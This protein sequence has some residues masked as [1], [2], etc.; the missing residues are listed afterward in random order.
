MKATISP[1]GTAAVR[2]DA[3]TKRFR[4]SSGTY[5]AREDITFNARLGAFV[6]LIGPSRCG[7]STIPNMVAGP[8]K[9][10]I[11]LIF[12]VVL[13][14]SFAL[15]ACSRS[16][17]TGSAGAVV[18]IAIGGRGALDFLP[19]YL[20]SALG[21][22]R[23]EG[24]IVEIQDFPGTSKA[25]QALLGGSA[26]VVAG[27]YE[28]VIHMAGRGQPV[29]AIAVLERWMPFLIVV[30][31]SQR[32]TLRSISDLKGK[33]IGVASQGST[34]HQFLNYIVSR[35]GIPPSEVTA[36]AVGV[37]VSLAAAV[38]QSSVDAAVTGPYGYSLVGAHGTTIL[39]DCRTAEGAKQILGTD[40]LPNAALI[41]KT[42]WTAANKDTAQRLGRALR[43]VLGWMQAHSAEEIAA[44][45]PF[46]YKPQDGA[47]YIRAVRE[48]LPVFS[49]DGAMPLEGPSSVRKF[50]SASPTGVS[51][52]PIDLPSTY[53]NQFIAAQ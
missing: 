15:T 9:P 19:V 38:R 32:S 39:A 31:P 30:A 6:S 5:T 45:M 46:E 1:A 16:E 28:S 23:A 14:M 20:A 26:D 2:L 36:V 18:R 37:N 21:H 42:S 50:L 13:I 52:T 34:T 43:R 53:T 35:H 11:G 27:G 24:L 33:R 47:S 8:V 29:H 44:A 48:M 3:L 4:S 40:N 25:M 7:K 17:N 12:L 51:E 22:F 10:C 41:V 49:P